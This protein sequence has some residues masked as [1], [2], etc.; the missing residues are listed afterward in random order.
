MMRQNIAATIALPVQLRSHIFFTEI[1]Y[2]QYMNSR[3]LSYLILS[4]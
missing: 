3:I 4:M 2:M 1:A